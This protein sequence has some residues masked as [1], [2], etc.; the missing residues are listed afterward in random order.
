D[1]REKQTAGNGRDCLLS[2]KVKLMG[3]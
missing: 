2:E 3:G 1:G